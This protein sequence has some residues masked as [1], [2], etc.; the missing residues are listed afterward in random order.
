MPRNYN[1]ILLCGVLFILKFSDTKYTFTFG[2]DGRA[3][4]E[5]V[6]VKDK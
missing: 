3:K 6:S 5:K 2:G 4:I 1:Y